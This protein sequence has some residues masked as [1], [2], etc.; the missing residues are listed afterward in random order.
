AP[1]QVVN[2]RGVDRY[3]LEL[4]AGEL[5]RDLAPELPDLPLHLADARL[6]RIARDDLAERSVRDRELLQRE[7]VLTHLPRDQ[8]AL[9]DLQLF[10]L[11]VAR[12]GHG[13]QPVEQRAGDALRKVRGRDEQHFRQ[14]EGHSQVV[15]R[16]RIVLR[17]IE[18]LE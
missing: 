7:A 1:E 14:V 10:T 11:G 4:A 8:I 5:A 16:E 15:I 2:V 12:E 6:T 13:L 18:H 17:R 3:A 9:R